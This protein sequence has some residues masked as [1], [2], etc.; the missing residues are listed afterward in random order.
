MNPNQACST[1]S[2]ILR[3][4]CTD[5]SRPKV[6]SQRLATLGSAPIHSTEMA[7]SASSVTPFYSIYSAPVEI[8]YIALSRGTSENWSTLAMSAESCNR[9]IA[10]A[11]GPFKQAPTGDSNE[12]SSLCRLC[13]SDFGRQFF[14]DSIFTTWKTLDKSSCQF[15]CTSGNPCT[16]QKKPFGTKILVESYTL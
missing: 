12:E 13:S 7:T 15:P 11:P 1:G 10:T 16:S 14:C 2:T 5:Q 4:I 9:L 3:S 8:P 6:T